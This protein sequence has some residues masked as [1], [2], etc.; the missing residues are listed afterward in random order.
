MT[1]QARLGEAALTDTASRGGRAG[2]EASNCDTRATGRARSQGRG[3]R[4]AALGAAQWPISRAAGSLGN[5][6]SPQSRR[7]ATGASPPPQRHSSRHEQGRVVKSRHFLTG[8]G[9]IRARRADATTSPPG[10]LF[11]VSTSASPAPSRRAPTAGSL[12]RVQVDHQV[13]QRGLQ[14][15]GHG[16]HPPPPGGAARRRSAPSGGAEEFGAEAARPCRS[17]SGPGRWGG[18][19]PRARRE[20]SALEGFH[21]LGIKQANYRARF[22]WFSQAQGLRENTV[23]LRPDASSPRRRQGGRQPGW[24]TQEP[25]LKG[26]A[27]NGDTPRSKLLR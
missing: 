3:R 17:P 16:R 10:V 5:L 18:R 12:L 20:S 15:H 1:R 13:A 25:F 8:S 19:A 26:I 2:S 11:R 22:L 6:R 14:Q 27:E 23:R 7:E 21:I 24:R 9:A 4:R